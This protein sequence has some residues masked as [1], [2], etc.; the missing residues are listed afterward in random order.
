MRFIPVSLSLIAI[1]MFVPTRLE[2]C[3]CVCEFFF[4]QAYSSWESM[5][6]KTKRKEEG[7]EGVNKNRH[8]QEDKDEKDS[9]VS[10]NKLTARLKKINYVLRQKALE[11]Q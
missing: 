8:K 1:R 9:K 7:W 4:A 2:M 3:V 5:F 11:V 10:R 6:F